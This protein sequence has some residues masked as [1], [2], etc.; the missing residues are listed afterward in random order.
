MNKLPALEKEEIER[1]K[2]DSLLA[3]EGQLN[4]GTKHNR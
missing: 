2:Q 4:K 1:K 3:I